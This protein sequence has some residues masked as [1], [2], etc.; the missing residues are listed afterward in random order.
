MQRGI[1][2]RVT[3]HPANDSFPIWLPHR[4]G[5]RVLINSQRKPFV[6]AKNGCQFGALKPRCFNSTGLFIRVLKRPTAF[7]NCLRDRPRTATSTSGRYVLMA[8]ENWCGRS[9]L[10]STNGVRSCLPTARWLAYSSAQSG[11]PEVFVTEFPGPGEKIPISNG[12]GYEPKWRAD[13]RELFYIAKDGQLMS[14]AIAPGPTLD[15]GR[16]QALFQTKLDVVNLPFFWRYDVAPDGQR[17][18]MIQPSHDRATAAA[19]V[20]LNWQVLMPR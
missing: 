20:V 17:F 3:S 4:R 13:G 9:I 1:P 12:G 14:V 5:D 16:S 10:S 6:V 2:T 11:R 19:T 15:V 7:G 18:L 8:A